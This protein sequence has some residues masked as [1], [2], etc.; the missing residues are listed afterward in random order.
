MQAESP[1]TISLTE[2]DHFREDIAVVA[3]PGDLRFKWRKNGVGFVGSEGG[4]FVNG[5]TIGGRKVTKQDAGIYTL[6]AA[7]SIGDASFTV[8]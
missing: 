4:I 1:L 5:P 8:R 2:G 6:L 7:N 3:N